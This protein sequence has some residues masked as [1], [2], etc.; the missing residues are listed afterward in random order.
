MFE[1]IQNIAQLIVNVIAFVVHAFTFL[2]E[3][4]TSTPKALSYITGVVATLPSYVGGVIMISI[5]IA[6]ILTIIN[7]GSD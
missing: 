7:H 3:L 4:F 1:F 6:V 2:I 5:S